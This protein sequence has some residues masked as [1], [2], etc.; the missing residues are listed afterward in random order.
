MHDDSFGIDWIILWG[1]PGYLVVDQLGL[2]HKYE[3]ISPYALN[4]SFIFNIL[5]LCSDLSGDKRA[6]TVFCPSSPN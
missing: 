4:V 5:F 6:K 3:T 1:M 2:V